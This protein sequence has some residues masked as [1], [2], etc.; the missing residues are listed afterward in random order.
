MERR[1]TTSLRIAAW[2][3]LFGTVWILVSDH[4]VHTLAPSPG[5]AATWQTVKGW[6]F[7]VAS[8]AL[9]FWLIRR[10]VRQR[11]PLR[12]LFRTALRAVPDP[13][14][15]THLETGK[16][17]STNDA[18]VDYFGEGP[19]DV[20]G[21]TTHELGLWTHPGDREAFRTTL[22]QDGEVRNEHTMMTTVEGE[23][24]PMLFSSRRVELEG[25]PYLVSVAREV[26]ELE[27]TK[28]R[29]ES[30]VR[31]LDA[32]RDIDLAI[33]GSLDLRLTLEVILRQVLEHLGVDAADVLL[34]E[35]E[36]EV[37]RY[38]KGAGFRT[39]AL[40][41][42]ELEFGEGH[43]GRAAAE[44]ETVQVAD[45]R[46]E[47]RAFAGSDAFEKEGFVYYAATPLVTKGEVNG[48]LEVFHRDPFEPDESWRDFLEAIA[49]QSAIAVENSDLLQSV[50]DRARELRRA[51][52]ATI[53]GWSKAL[54]L[55]DDETQG[56][57]ER[58]TEATMKLARR[59]GLEG[60]ELLHARRGALLHDIGK[61]AIPD[62]ILNKPGPLDDEEWEQMREHPGIA[63]R[64]LA[65]IE[66][67]RPAIPIPYCHHEWWDGTGYPRGLEGEEI[68]LA[69]RVF[70][71]VDV[72]DALRSDRPYRK[73]WPVEKVL[74][75]LRDEAG[76]HFDPEV[77]EAFLELHEEVDLESG[78][79]G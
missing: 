44:R 42:T 2:Y 51:Y 14:A 29:L 54:E 52:D 41:H 23:A 73:A 66:F 7:V 57:T 61:I 48:V 10:E 15:L 33:T 36:L 62:A 31:R 70:A 43:A 71:V 47:P 34:V 45:L 32:L 59:I 18:F 19:G 39:E 27:T 40:R 72:W 56:H 12:N 11:G 6:V 49:A 55:R 17:V 4:L 8:A 35:P 64:L 21:K 28:R 53:V 60:E 78:R 3:A 25:E 79:S 30:Q 46:D 5:A 76:T 74:D 37:L 77:V 63:Q 16:V 1:Q 50:R 22:E 75:H 58:V 65:P 67:L 24:V 13:M 20:L 68:P 38:G 9:I 26:T 69:A